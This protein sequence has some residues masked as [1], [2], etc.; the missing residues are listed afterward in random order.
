[1]ADLA[2]TILFTAIALIAVT[3]LTIALRHLVATAREI[4]AAL[5]RTPESLFIHTEVT[6]Q[7]VTPLTAAPIR[8][9]TR[10]AQAN[11]TLAPRQAA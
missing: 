10:R 3:S 6:S 1:M 2:P 11:D 8:R 9:A 4:R 7:I 5:R